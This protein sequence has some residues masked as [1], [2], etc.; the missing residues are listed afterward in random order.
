MYSS[1]GIDTTLDVGVLVEMVVKLVLQPENYLNEL[2][3]CSQQ[4][5]SL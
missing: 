1:F 3:V 2:R 4:K 5:S